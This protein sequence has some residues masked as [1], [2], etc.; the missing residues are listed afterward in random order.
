MSTLQRAIEI[1][2]S[3]HRGQIR[4]NGL[5]YILHPMRVMLRQKDEE[6][7]IAAILHDV[8]EDTDVT[9]ADLEKEGFTPHVLD[10]VRRLTHEEDVSYG[11]YI[12]SVA[13]NSIARAVK[14]ADLEDNMQLAE[15][16]EVSEKDCERLRK[17]HVAWR[18][19][20]GG[21]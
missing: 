2:V 1:A 15:I 8:V 4:R 16:S 9:H 12:E 17:Y 21:L 20:K 7:M 10:A 5:P 14:L 13:G 19:L 11:D 18:H 6:S 3:A